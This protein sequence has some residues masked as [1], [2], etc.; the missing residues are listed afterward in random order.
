MMSRRARIVR[1]LMAATCRLLLL[2]AVLSV[3]FSGPAQA[4][5][6]ANQLRLSAFV[7]AEGDRLMLVLRVP[8]EL[9]LNVDLPK[10]GNGYLDLAGADQAFP[11]AIAA[12]AKDIEL[13]A[14]G[15]RLSVARAD[16]RIALPSDKSFA[17]YAQAIAAVRGPRLPPDTQ[18]FWNQGY[19]DAVLEYPI[20][21]ATDAFAIDFHVA[22]GLRDRLKMD[23]RYVTPEADVRA[24][25]IATGSGLVALDPRW[26][27]AAATFVGSGF[28]HILGGTDH[29]LFLLCLILPFRRVGWPLVGVVT[30]FTA[31]HTVTLIAAAYGHVPSAT[32]FP[33]L[34]ETLIAASILY[35]A[36]ENV[37]RPNLRWR[38]L[39]TAVFGLVHGFGFSFGLT[40]EL[41]FAGSHLL[42]SLLA[43]NIG[44]ELGQLLVLALVW[45]LLAALL[46]RAKGVE[47][48]AVAAICVFVGH[49]AW[50][51]MTERFEAFRAANPPEIDAALIAQSASVLLLVFAIAMFAK[52]LRRRAP[53][54]HDAAAAI[55][56]RPD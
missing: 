38:W 5:D 42:V 20:R 22:R 29:L 51:W 50:H 32:W 6:V 21:S 40:Q 36:I 47:R 14:N 23:L 33:P 12:A 31:A 4:H 2:A 53:T 25:E 37:V 43:F 28:R 34:V 1:C 56:P 19:F 16:A 46:A 54:P 7:R 55:A 18:V 41:Q 15:E 11:R 27:Q 10:Q 44:V 48:I 17:T 9:L 13:F 49:A 39:L 3:T 24:F 30:A 52:S 26:Y 45:P 8:L 35:M